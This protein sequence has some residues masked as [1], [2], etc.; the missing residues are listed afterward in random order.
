MRFELTIIQSII[1]QIAPENLDG[2][3]IE[4]E[5]YKYKTLSGKETERI[6]RAFIDEVFSLK[7]DKQIEKYIQ[8]HQSVIIRCTDNLL[9]YFSPTDLNSIYSYDSSPTLVNLY[10]HIYCNLEELLSYIESYFSKYFNLEDKIPDSYLFIA[11]REFNEKITKYKRKTF[12]TQNCELESLALSPIN[13]FRANSEITTFKHLIFLKELLNTIFGSCKNCKKAEFNCKLQRNLIY[14]NYNSYRFFCYMINEIIQQYQSKETLS[15]Q[16][17]ILSFH[18]K[19][20][21]QTQQKPGFI[22]KPGHYAISDR[23]LSWLIE[24]IAFL[25]KRQQLTINFERSYN[26]KL[27]KDFKILTDHSVAQVAYFIRLLVEVGAIL[28]KN[29]KEL[30]NFFASYISSKHAQQISPDSFRTKYYNIEEKSINVIRDL[31]IKLLN[32]TNKRE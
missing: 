26:E 31:I 12:N 9:K 32:E 22:Y 20:I 7:R 5:F 24:E 19:Y 14:L 29:Q 4:E 8:Q 25:E 16:I 6:K 10:K 18:L 1:K 17:E 13:R 28:N 27:R 30:I 23:M 11:K 2:K 21:N 3:N 15:E